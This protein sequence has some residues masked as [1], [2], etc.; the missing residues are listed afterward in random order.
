[1]G[2][3]GTWKG[4]VHGKGG[5]IGRGVHGKGGYMGREAGEREGERVCIR[6]ERKDGTWKGREGRK[7][8][9]GM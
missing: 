9:E 6:E 1:M 5:Y 8:R 2:R 3:E 4:R 7:L